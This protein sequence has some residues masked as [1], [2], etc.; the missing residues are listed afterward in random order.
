MSVATNVAEIR[1]RMAS[2]AR[3]AGRS[4]DDI[5][6]MAVSKNFPPE[7]LREA[8]EAGIR[9]FGENRVQE[10][11]GK[12]LMLADLKD[13]GVAHDWPSADQQSGQSGGIVQRGRFGRF[14][15]IGGKAE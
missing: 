9:V 5:T 15:A 8:Y 12:A 13:A 11:S 4:P 2:A 3:R 14:I 10:F 7:L 6:L 1:E